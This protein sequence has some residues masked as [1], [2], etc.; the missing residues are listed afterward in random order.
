MNTGRSVACE[1]SCQQWPLLQCFINLA[2]VTGLLGTAGGVPARM[3]EWLRV[4]AP[5]KQHVLFGFFT[6]TPCHKSAHFP[7]SIAQAW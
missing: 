1:S 7:M 5:Y 4:Q 6:K 2:C 3:Q